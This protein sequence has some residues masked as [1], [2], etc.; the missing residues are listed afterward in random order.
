MV[1][2]WET[3]TEVKIDLLCWSHPAVNPLSLNVITFTQMWLHSVN[4]I[5]EKLQATKPE[6][7]NW[8]S[9]Q[10]Q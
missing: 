8:N 4:I 7:G 6:K 2:N 5:F 3:S 9:I 10:M 1:K